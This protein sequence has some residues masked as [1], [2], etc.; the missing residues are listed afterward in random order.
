MGVSFFVQGL[1]KEGT[2]V[3]HLTALLLKLAAYLLIFGTCLSLLG[4]LALPRALI[5]AGVQT[6]VL[7]IVD[8]L[9]LPWLKQPLR[10]VSASAR[11]WRP[12]ETAALVADGFLLLFGS[13]LV[14]GAIGS[15]PRP[16]GVLAAVGLATAFEGW[17]HQQLKVSGVKVISGNLFEHRGNGRIRDESTP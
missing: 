14:L 5:L 2:P 16:L 6:L 7:W 9:I 11:R 8:L 15:V 12:G 4:N 1:A 3:R 10:P 17:F 13:L